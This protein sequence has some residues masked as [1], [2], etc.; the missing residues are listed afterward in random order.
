MSW[1]YR[2][3]NL[4]EYAAL[5]NA[6]ILY[7]LKYDSVSHRIDTMWAHEWLVKYV[8]DADPGYLSS[9]SPFPDSPESSAMEEPIQSS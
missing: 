4:R 6:P 8:L 1:Q 7:C 5:D 3:P 2:I 9:P